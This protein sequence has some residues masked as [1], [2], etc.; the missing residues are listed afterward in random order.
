[1]SIKDVEQDRIALTKIIRF[2]VKEKSPWL[3]TMAEC[4]YELSYPQMRGLLQYFAELEIWKVINQ[5]FEDE[6]Q[7]ASCWGNIC[8]YFTGREEVSTEPD[9]KEFMQHI[10]DYVS[11]DH[12]KH[13]TEETT[14]GETRAAFGEL[15]E[16]L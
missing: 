2:T 11:S 15:L 7:W 14:H 1:M 16:E 10:K 5:K 6:S 12:Y 3:A 9:R 4:F 13:A 8:Y